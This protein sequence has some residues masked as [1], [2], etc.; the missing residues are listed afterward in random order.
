MTSLF[1]ALRASSMRVASKSPVF[2]LPMPR[3][4]PLSTLN[5]YRNQR[6]HLNTRRWN[7][8]WNSSVASAPSTLPPV[9]PT[10]DSEV[11][12]GLLPDVAALPPLQHGDLHALG[13]CNFTPVGLLQY[14]FEVIHLWTGL[15]WFHTFIVATI[16]WRVVIFP[17]AVV[18]MRN[19]T[20]MR[21]VAAQL[22][23]MSQAIQHARAMGDT[24]AMQK[25]SLEAA[26]IRASAGVSMGGLIAP[27][28]QI[29]ISISMFFGV[30]KMCELPVMQLMQSGFEWIPDLT[31]PGPYY[32]LPILAA[33]SGNVMISM[34]AR[35][36]D[37]SRPG[38]GH[39]MNGVRL[40]TIAFIPWMNGFPS[41][42]LLCLLVTS[43]ATLVQTSIFR[44]PAFRA[45]LKIPQ[46]TPPA[47]G[48]P[49]LPTMLDT[50]RYVRSKLMKSTAPEDASGVKPYVPPGG[51]STTGFKVLPTAIKMQAPAAAPRA[52][53]L[54]AQQAQAKARAN[55][56]ASSLFEDAAPATAPKPPKNAPA[57]KSPPKS[58]A[59]AAKKPKTKSS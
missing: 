7:A 29:P 41:G 40:L 57:S 31:Q 51:N 39:V 11:V 34:S 14:S 54:M 15:P 25:A 53:D 49:K 37:T 22:T 9:P 28:I 20:R 16:F 5:L 48:A 13:L 38:I 19:S 26:K 4:R 1:G 56:S 36:M 12:T 55:N 46:W 27:M 45:A 59:K 52:S 21:P 18:G 42:L 23:A 6:P 32:I 35:D 58:K 24:V 44:V 8:R 50:F 43:V 47:P 2:S 30:K 3:H 10:W 33:A 17:F